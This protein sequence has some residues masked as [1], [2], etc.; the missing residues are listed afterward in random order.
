M[1]GE[2]L[3]ESSG[4]ITGQRIL[5]ADGPKIESSFTSV[6]RIKGIEMTEMATFW[7]IPRPGGAAM[8]GEGNGVMMATNGEHVTWSGNGIGKYGEGGKVIWRGA[9][10]LQTSPIGKL[11]SLNNVV[12]VFEFE[13]DAMGNTTEKSWE[14]K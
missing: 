6:G 1:L 8:Y 9:V 5:S 10:Y 4:K 3:S 13:A 7:S 2:V 12:A 11:N 14:W